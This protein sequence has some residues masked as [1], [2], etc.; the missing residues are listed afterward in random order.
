MTHFP[1]LENGAP[2]QYPLK[3]KWD[4]FRTEAVAQGG[5]VW[6]WFDARSQ[7]RHWILSLS[8]LTLREK[9]LLEDHFRDRGGRLKSFLFMDPAGNLLRWSDDLTKSVWSVS[10]GIITSEG[11]IDPEGHEGAFQL[12]NVTQAPQA[13]SQVLAAPGDGCYAFS[14]ALRNMN[15]GVA[16]L[17]IRSG[18]GQRSQQIEVRDSWVRSEVTSSGLSSADSVEFG[19]ELPAGGVIDVFGPQVEAQPAASTYKRT[20]GEGGTYLQ[21]RFDQDEIV[22]QAAGP[23]DYSTII[24]VFAQIQG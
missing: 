17:F 12:S 2:A 4:H 3:R 10:P 8:G 11:R 16:N 24:R 1:K 7:T 21:A 13:L 9:T 15:G 20:T 6:N 18:S 23:D 5:Q 22:F 19:V 14:L